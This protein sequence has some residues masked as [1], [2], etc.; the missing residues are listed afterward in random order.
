MIKV[1]VIGAGVMGENHIRTY[2]NIPDL[3]LVGISDVREEQVSSVARKYGT[4]P[5]TDHKEL[6]ALKPDIVSVVTPTLTHKQVTID[7]FNAGS[8]VLVEKPIAGN[9]PDAQEMVS[10]AKRLGLKLMVGHIERFNPAAMALK[11]S[12]DEKRIGDLVS[13]SIKRVGPYSPRIRDVG[14][15]MDLGVHDIDLL[16]FLLGERTR[17]VYASA[18][19]TIH[20]AE[21]HATLMFGFSNGYSAVLET[22]WL[23]PHKVRTITVVGTHGIAVADLMKPSLTIHNKDWVRTAKIETHEPLRAELEH[24]IDCVKNDKE[25]LVSGEDG[26]AALRVALNAID[27]YKSKKVINIDHKEGELSG[28]QV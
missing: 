1:A 3:E 28:T 2:S 19:R 25:P 18:G 23:T 22:N 4:R 26:I 27:S 6:L 14:I 20:S 16:H 21:D 7:C 15:I 13:I 12:L 10:H 17:T 9:I 11:R 24:F 8:N 5:F